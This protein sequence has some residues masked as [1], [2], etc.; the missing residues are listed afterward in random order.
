MLKEKKKFQIKKKIEQ[1]CEWKN[2]FSAEEV[3][4]QEESKQGK[5]E[6]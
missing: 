5:V 4:Q 3:N 6:V 2:C 1:M